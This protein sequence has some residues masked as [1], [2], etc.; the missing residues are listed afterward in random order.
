M[1][2][3]PTTELQKPVEENPRPPLLTPFQ[4][5]G[6]RLQATLLDH[7]WAV[8]LTIILILFILPSTESV[9]LTLSVVIFLTAFIF[10]L[11]ETGKRRGSAGLSLMGLNLIPNGFF[12]L[13]VRN[14]LKYTP[15]M[16]LLTLLVGLVL[17]AQGAQSLQWLLG[18]CVLIECYNGVS[19]LLGHE[20]L[21]N[22][23]SGIKVTITPIPPRHGRLYGTLLVWGTLGGIGVAAALPNFS[24]SCS[25]SPISSV[26]ANMHTLQ[27]IAETYAVDWGG[28]YAPT[29][30]V[31]KQEAEKGKNAYWKDFTNP[32]SGYSGLE[33]SYANESDAK[34]EGFVTYEP[35]APHFTHYFI[36]G[37]D[38]KGQRVQDKGQDFFLTNS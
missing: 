25:R 23:L 27:T 31:L 13:L 8:L 28:Q 24:G 9:L 34:S 26:K 22:Q 17:G 18:A 2:D 32:F 4:L 6:R 11:F 19:L 36:Y 16:T 1:M 21:H 12:R 15:A 7:T 37:Y 30:Q 14:L 10:A 33:K 5:L 3:K 20:A 35:I 38:K 29:V